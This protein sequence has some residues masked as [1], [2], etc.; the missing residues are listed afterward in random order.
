MHHSYAQRTTFQ[1]IFSATVIVSSL[2]YF[3]DIYDLVLF[4]IIRVP[5]LK[6]MGIS[7][8]ALLDTGIYLLNVQMVGMLIGG[9]TWGVLGDKKGRLSVLIGSILLYSTANIA[10]GFVHTVP[11]YAIMRFI[12]GIGLAGGRW[13][14]GS[15]FVRV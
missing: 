6:S 15:I 10:N 2:G 13:A 11:Q 1:A 7:G 3:V 5:S 4:S 9:L 14:A 12:A 8:P